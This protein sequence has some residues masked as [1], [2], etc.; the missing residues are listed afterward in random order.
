[1]RVAQAHAWVMYDEPADR[2][3]FMDWFEQIRQ[4]EQDGADTE[5]LYRAM[6]HTG[7]SIRIS[8]HIEAV[9]SLRKEPK[10]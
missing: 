8:A 7:D 6:V 3:V 2:E 1:M 10:R 4:F 5:R 9:A